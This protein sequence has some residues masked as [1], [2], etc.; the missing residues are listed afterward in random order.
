VQK[1]IQEFIDNTG[2]IR[3]FIVLI[4]FA[5]FPTLFSS[6]VIF[7]IKDIVFTYTVSNTDAIIFFLLSII[8][9]SFALTPTTFISIITGY[10]FGWAGLIPM[11]VAYGFACILGLKT[12]KFLNHYFVGDH[13]FQNKKLHQF[14]LR[15][16]QEEFLLVFFGRLSPVLPF[17]M[18]NIAFASIELNTRKYLVASISGAFP[19]TFLFFYVGNSVSEVWDFVLHPSL[20]GSYTLLPVA[21]VIISTI[22][23]IIVFRKV[24][25]LKIEEKK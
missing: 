24:L 16:H 19:R 18:M 7:Y 14:F 25:K 17:A 23:L 6:T 11:L 3:F 2:G 8:T 5:V 4:V 13:L 9:M 10:F 1:K 15:L 12:G 21:L 22:G 20:E